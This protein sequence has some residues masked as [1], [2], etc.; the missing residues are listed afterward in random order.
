MK[1]QLLI[2]LLTIATLTHAQEVVQKGKPV[3]FSK[4]PLEVSS[5]H[6]FLQH[7]DGSPFF[8]LGDTAWELFHRLNKI[9]T[10][11]YLE[12]RREKGF[13]VIEAAAL[14]E[15]NGITEPNAFGHVPFV[16]QDPLK[17]NEKYWQ[18]ID[19]VIFS[20]KE[21]GMYVGL[22]PTWGDKV[23][24]QWGRDPVL[25]NP[26][27]A[28]EYGK[29]IGERYKDAVNIIWIIGGDRSG[30]GNNY[31][32]WDAMAKGI[33]SADTNHLMSYH[34][35]RGH[36]SSEWFH[37]SD[38]LDFNM[39]QTGHGAR[40][41]A[42]YRQLISS[43]YMLSLV[44]PTM[45]GEPR[46]E[47]HPVDRKPEELG[48][49]NDTDVRQ[50]VY[51]SLFSGA[52]GHV[53]GAHP[54]WQMK[55]PDKDPEGFVRRNWFEAMDLPGAWDMIHARHLIESRPFFD[56]RPSPELI[57]N[58]YQTE[59]NFIVATRG[60][61]YA[62]VYIPTGKPA[63]L[64]LN[65]LNWDTA[66]TWWYNC[67]NGEVKNAGEIKAKGIREFYIP[68]NSGRGNDWVLILDNTEMNFPEP[69][70]VQNN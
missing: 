33:K 69:G 17:P 62:M 9:D 18:N 59:T 42:V 19:Q 46:Y 31:D 23:D 34:P 20:A 5:N 30:G 53:Y 66:Q 47:D 38:W 55:T 11:K 27:N 39:V 36:S 3:D 16:D 51:W 37:Q 68:G 44:K 4:G 60:D 26:Q 58:K 6:R 70:H 8:Y 61:H 45:D 12:N 25:F 2:L 56:R 40:S 41:Y 13:T 28:F 52:F 32:T 43:D 24:K 48:W 1:C 35:W 22:L 14:A 54:I 10:E 65:Q 21:K 29:W 50:A 57:L 15:L 49:F 7:A 67:K 64:D 63:Q